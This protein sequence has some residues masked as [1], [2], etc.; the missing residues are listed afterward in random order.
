MA[1]VV[2]IPNLKEIASTCVA[3]ALWKHIDLPS[4][5]WA[6][7]NDENSDFPLIRHVFESMKK[8]KVPQRITELLK[9]QVQKVKEE[10]KDWVLY[11]SYDVLRCNGRKNELYYDLN[12]I[13][14][15]SDGTINRKA[16]ARNLLNSLRFSEIE[17]YHIL[18][19]YS[20]IDDIDRLSPLL[21]TKNIVDHVEFRDDA[22]IYYW[23]CYFR[24]ELDKVP[25]EGNLSLDVFM[26]RHEALYWW[27]AKEP[28]FDRLNAEEQV[29]NIIWLIDHDGDTY[30]YIKLALMKLSENQLI[31]VYMA[32]AVE[33]IDLFLQDDNNYKEV[34]S[35]WYDFRDFITQEQFVSVFTTLLDSH[36]PGAILTEIWTSAGDDFRA[37]ILNQEHVIF[38]K[39]LNWFKK[40]G[41]ESFL[42]TL[43]QYANEN[44]KQEM[45]TGPFF[46]KFCEE[47][48]DQIH[49]VKLTKLERL[50]NEWSLSDGDNLI[51]FKREFTKTTLFADVCDSVL[52]DAI[53]EDEEDIT[54]SKLKALEQLW[55]IWFTNAE[56][57]TSFKQDFTGKVLFQNCCK[58]LF[59]YERFYALESLLNLCLADDGEFERNFTKN[60]YL[61]DYCKEFMVPGKVCFLQQILKACFGNIRLLT[62]FQNK[63]ITERF[64]VDRCER[65]I[66]RKDFFFLKML[67]DC[68]LSNADAE[69]AKKFKLNFVED[70]VKSRFNSF[71]HYWEPADVNQL[72]N[73]CLPKSP[74]SVQFMRNL[75]FN[76]ANLRHHCFWWYRTPSMINDLLM[77]LLLSQP[78]LVSEYKKHIWLSSSG[79]YKAERIFSENGGNALNE[80]IADIFADDTDSANELKKNFAFCPEYMKKLQQM[81]LDGE[82]L[83]QVKKH[84]DIFLQSNEDRR[85]LKKQLI[86]NLQPKIAEIFHNYGHSGWQ[87]LM[88]WYIEDKKSVRELKW[89]LPIDDIFE[90]VFKDCIFQTYDEHHRVYRCTLKKNFVFDSIDVLLNWYFETPKERKEYKIQKLDAYENIKT[91]S[92]LLKKNCHSSYV[93]KLMDWFFEN[94]LVEMA[95]FKKKHKGEHFVNMI[96]I[97]RESYFG[98]RRTL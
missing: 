65:V 55:N 45:I 46:R 20:L 81:I 80:I 89:K 44:L 16:T 70:M 28:F 50:F 26:F 52:K 91:I 13:V 7:H 43:L 78:N 2:R 61:Y 17:K 6:N 95:K 36:V 27:S 4:I 40:A 48:I 9:T 11:L 12:D 60:I 54:L 30:S 5:L 92:T 84:I 51:Q 49:D 1:P 53:N 59:V 97:C 71:L 58:K 87:S 41:D 83:S 57:V 82:A 25:K 69:Q 64:F 79:T 74:E 93:T 19:H 3:V 32:R 37:Y 24:K 68:C 33:I 62:E 14:W 42:N 96:R 39:T 31:Q 38:E 34:I 86:D 73:L 90:R 23:N 47:L 94:D 63:L 21:F 77:E 85:A 18:C 29:E 88:D 8:L 67:F 76:S 15:Y 10:L 98:N 56:E 35:T 66:E 75:V 72:L 22:S